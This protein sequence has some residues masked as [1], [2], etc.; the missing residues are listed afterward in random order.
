MGNEWDTEG[1]EEDE[2]DFP[3]KP[4]GDDDLEAGLDEDPLDAD[5]AREDGFAADADDEDG[6]T[7]LGENFLI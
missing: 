4:K 1:K 2:I 7:S 3:K 5:D 6:T